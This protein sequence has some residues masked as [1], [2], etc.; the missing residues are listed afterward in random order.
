[1]SKC[2]LC[3]ANL[4]S[5]VERESGVCILCGHT[6]QSTSE[7]ITKMEYQNIIREDKTLPEDI[8]KLSYALMIIG[9]IVIAIAITFL[10]RTLWI[11]ANSQAVSIAFLAISGFIAV[12]IINQGIGI[13]SIVN[14]VRLNF[15]TQ[16]ILL[17][18]F[19]I[20]TAG[21]AWYLT[22]YVISQNEMQGIDFKP[23]TIK[24]KLYVPYCLGFVALLWAYLVALLVKKLS[25]D[26]IREVFEADKE[27]SSIIS[28]DDK[29]FF[30]RSHNE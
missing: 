11:G 3:G 26:D 22:V 23:W 20:V 12:K 4:I 17:L 25:A 19:A 14:L 18:L 13:I 15:L 8:K 28:D 29:P 6:V 10:V 5:S 30:T 24:E 1:M 2:T 16:S 27:I 21:V 9:L 7:V